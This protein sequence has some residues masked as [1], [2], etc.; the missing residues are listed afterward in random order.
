MILVDT[1]IWI[2]W[3]R[4]GNR[5]RFTDFELLNLATCG[6]VVQEVLQGV[7][8]ETQASRV[9]GILRAMP[10]L[11]NP[12]KRSTFEHAA[13][14]YR[15]GRRTGITVRSSHDCLIAAIALENSASVWHHDRDFDQIARFT[16]LQAINRRP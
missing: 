1:S 10:L 15:I 3:L 6:P 13:E 7:R 16:S 8:Q 9:R 4:P 14:I 5:H 12:L 2:D 11:C